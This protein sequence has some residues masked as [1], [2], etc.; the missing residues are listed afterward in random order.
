MRSALIVLYID[1][2]LTDRRL[3][4]GITTESRPQERKMKPVYTSI[5]ASA[6]PLNHWPS[7]ANEYRISHFPKLSTSVEQDRPVGWRNKSSVIPR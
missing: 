1:V 4:S 7:M 3:L 5:M 6:V 2:A